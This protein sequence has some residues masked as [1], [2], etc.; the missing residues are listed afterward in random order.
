MI[1]THLLSCITATLIPSIY[2][3]V[4][5]FHH[6]LE[7]WAFLQ[8]RFT[9]LSRS[10]VHQL[11]NK[12]NSVAKK[13][14]T[15]EEYLSK[16]KV[17][18]SQLAL[19]SVIIDDKDLVLITLNGLPL[20]YDD[21]STTVLS[22]KKYAQDIILKASM[23]DCKACSSPIFVKPGLPAHSNEPF[24][25]PSVYRNIVGALQYLTITR[26]D[27]SFAVNQLCQHMYN[28]T[29][30]HYVG[31]KRLLRFIKG[32]I[33]HGLTY[34]PSSFDL[35]AYSDSNWARDSVDRKSTSG[36]CVFLGSNLISWS[37]KKQATISRS[38]A[39][40]EYRSLAHTIAKLAWLGMLL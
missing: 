1:D 8:K 36:Y 33:S 16:I 10:H 9:T 12:L 20:E 37:S 14:D 40:A 5:Q 30:G 38:S 31:I 28:P 34:N 29:V 17:I 19:A 7:V 27:I 13:S 2:A 21:F 6:C 18:V 4:L 22:Q 39:E 11:K 26:P 23:L 24:A 32:T 35:H 3:S 25:N 15:M